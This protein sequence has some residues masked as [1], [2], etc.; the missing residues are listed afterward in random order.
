LIGVAVP[1]PLEEFTELLEDCGAEAGPAEDL[2]AE[3]ERPYPDDD[4]EGAAVE[5]LAEDCL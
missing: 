3:D 2:D 5:R 1:W 4:L